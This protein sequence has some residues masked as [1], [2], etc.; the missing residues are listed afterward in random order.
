M[1]FWESFWNTL[2]EHI[3]KLLAA[4]VAV[5]LIAG[6][7]WLYHQVVIPIQVSSITRPA[8]TDFVAGEELR[9]SLTGVESQNV[10]WIFDEDPAHFV[11][12]KGP[13]VHYTFQF[14]PKGQKD[15]LWDRRVDA[16]FKTGGRYSTATKLV[17]VTNTQFKAAIQV[18]PSSFEL[19][20]PSA[21]MGN[22]Y[23]SSAKLGTFEDAA[24][25]NKLDFTLLPGTAQGHGEGVVYQLQGK[26]DFLTKAL[27][28]RSNTWVTLDYKSREGNQSLRLIEPM[29]DLTNSKYRPPS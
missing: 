3:G 6:A 17:R 27:E 1:S 10:F 9:F 7:T 20:V 28:D 21:V 25:R 22:W 23:V 29:A 16:F 24:V 26:E 12:T 11:Q 4:A 5:I 13:E 19:T 8:V 18:K 15:A 2:K 14:D